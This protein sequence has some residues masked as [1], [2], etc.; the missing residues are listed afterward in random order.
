MP[1]SGSGSL[2]DLLRAQVGYAE[3]AQ[4]LFLATDAGLVLPLRGRDSLAVLLL[5]LLQPGLPGRFSNRIPSRLR[6]LLRSLVARL[7]GRKS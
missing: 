5:H 6:K 3:L 2:A 4:E 7:L 1:R